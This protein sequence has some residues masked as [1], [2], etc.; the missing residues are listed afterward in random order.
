MIESLFPQAEK[1]ELFARAE[2][3]GWDAWG[4]EI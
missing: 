3:A 2:R 4:N 1:L